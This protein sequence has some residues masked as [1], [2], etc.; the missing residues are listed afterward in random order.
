MSLNDR[1]S[2]ELFRIARLLERI[3][4]LLENPPKLTC[5]GFVLWNGNQCQCRL[6]AGHERPCS[7]T[8]VHHP[9]HKCECGATER[10]HACPL[11]PR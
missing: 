4:E 3:V 10:Q 7:V 9:G 11:R 2:D 8:V 1:E 6:P 5:P